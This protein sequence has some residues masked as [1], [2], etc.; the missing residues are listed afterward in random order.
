MISLFNN[1]KQ[2]LNHANNFKIFI[3]ITFFLISYV[4]IP[5]TRL[6]VL[7]GLILVIFPEIIK[8]VKY[9]LIRKENT[10]LSYKSIIL[11]YSNKLIDLVCYTGVIESYNE[12]YYMVPNN[13]SLLMYLWRGFIEMHR[14]RYYCEVVIGAFLFMGFVIL[15]PF[16]KFYYYKIETIINNLS[17]IPLSV[18][19]NVFNA[20]TDGQSI[21]F[22]IDNITILS[23]PPKYNTYMTEDELENIAPKI[24]PKT[25]LIITRK[26]KLHQNN[27]AICQDIIDISKEMSRVLP[28][29]KHT[30][31]CHCIDNWFFSGHYICPICRDQVK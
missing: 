20:I 25:Q 8:A 13:L 23:I 11:E 15:Y 24:M 7:K 6:P 22:H 21:D 30:F 16:F 18:Y 2:G 14:F 26:M 28:K 3:S 10:I 29:C 27:C 5:D 31:H 12:M 1:I 19:M 4:F 9:E 17:S